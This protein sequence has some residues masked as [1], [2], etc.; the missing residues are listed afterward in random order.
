MERPENGCLVMIKYQF[1][2]LKN[3]EKNNEQLLHNPG[4]N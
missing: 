2:S 1:D 4:V 3:F